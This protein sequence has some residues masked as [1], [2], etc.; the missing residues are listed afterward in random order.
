MPNRVGPQVRRAFAKLLLRSNAI[1]FTVGNIQRCL[2]DEKNLPVCPH[3]E[4]D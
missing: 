3:F 2:E 1:Y 4:M